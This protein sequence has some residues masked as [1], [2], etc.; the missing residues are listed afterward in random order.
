MIDDRWAPD[1]EQR[2]RFLTDGYLVVTPETIGPDHHRALYRRAEE[3]YERNRVASS[4][5]GHLDILGDNLQARVPE[6]ARLLADPA[7]DGTLANVLGPD[8]LLHPHSFCHRSSRRDQVF[9][10]D[11]NL[12]WNE[13]GYYRAHSSDWA[14]LFYYP[15]DV[16][17]DNGPTE[18]V[19]GSQYWTVDHEL[20]DG[21]WEPGDRVDRTVDDEVFGSDDLELRDRRQTEALDRGLGVPDLDR[22]FLHVPAGSVVIAHYDLIHRGSRVIGNPDPRYM[23]KFYFARVRQ[24]G[25]AAEDADATGAVAVNL[26]RRLNAGDPRRP[27]VEAQWRWLTGRTHPLQVDDSVL[28]VG[29]ADRLAD[30]L[31]GSREDRRISAAYRLG[32]A[33]AM[34]D[35]RA[36]SSLAAAL[37]APTE[38][39]RRAAGH[40]LRQAGAAGTDPLLGGLTAPAPTTRRPA[41][42]ALGSRA[43]AA[44][45]DAV[46]ALTELLANDPDDLVRS[47]AAYSL[48]TVGRCAA[49]P[50][51]S[52]VVDALLARLAP[53]VEPD[54]ADGAGFSRSTVRQ[55]AALSLAVVLANHRFGDRLIGAVVELLADESDRYVPGL[56]LE[57][58]MRTEH[59][60]K[61]HRRTLLTHLATRR[62]IEAY[63]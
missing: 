17:E 26:D 13:R 1:D 19:A 50:V 29:A 28:A 42:A 40:G 36:L 22:R 3:L 16:D 18:V 33:A 51:A 43:T 31:H 8:Y 55:T 44:D 48:G 61:A 24:P 53:G 49:P 57:G 5:T 34:G 4:S 6:I 20:A 21:G 38:A 56:L 14:M 47:N 63:R 58:L 27:V 46:V 52:M 41:A 54:N 32:R 30:D 7:V 11:G 12:P 37:A 60:G 35:E 23:Y 15:Q 39:T 10:Q 9:H 59:I 62:S 2:L 25:L 45:H